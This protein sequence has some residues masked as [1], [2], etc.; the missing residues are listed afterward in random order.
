MT[1]Q[2]YNKQHYDEKRKAPYKYQVHDYVMLRNF[3]S[4]AGVSTKLKSERKGPY[5]IIK[6]LENDRYVVQDISGFQNTQIPYE[7]IWEPNNMILYRRAKPLS[8][9][10]DQL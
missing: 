8:M 3:D 1:S 10:K 9:N 4:T 6:V 5:E 7:G 2:N